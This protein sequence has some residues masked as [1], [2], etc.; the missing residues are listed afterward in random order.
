MQPQNI[1]PGQQST[2]PRIFNFQTRDFVFVYDGVKDKEIWQQVAELKEVGGRL[3]I[4]VKGTDFFFDES[5]VVR[6][7]CDCPESEVA[8]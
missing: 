2:A 5:L 6:Y 1:T 7:L 4:R 3:K 8:A